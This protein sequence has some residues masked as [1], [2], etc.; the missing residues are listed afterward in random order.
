MNAERKILR[1]FVVGTYVSF[2]LGS[3]AELNGTWVE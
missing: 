3:L 1:R 2:L